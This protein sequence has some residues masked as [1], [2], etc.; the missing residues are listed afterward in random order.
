M[1]T[2]LPTDI[3]TIEQAKEFL[4]ALHG[5]GETFHPEDDAFDILWNMPEQDMPTMA[6]CERLNKLM[7]EIYNLEGNN[8]PQNMVFD[9]CGYLLDLD[10]N[11][12]FVSI[13]YGTI[14][15]NPATKNFTIKANSESDALEIGRER[16]RNYKR[17]MKIHGGSSVEIK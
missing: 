13:D 1:K 16:V 17:C 7:D 10:K 6:E 9:P 3:K 12:Y 8:D 4:S 14:K 15:G 11:S 5:N 2:P